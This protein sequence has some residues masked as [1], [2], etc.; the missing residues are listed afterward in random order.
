M[1]IEEE[2]LIEFDSYE[3][4]SFENKDELIEL[5]VDDFYIGDL[6][7]WKD[8]EMEDREY[9]CINYEIV[10]LDTLTERK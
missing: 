4:L 2:E 3:Q 9:V 8:S 1:L 5:F 10:Y 6:K 7:V